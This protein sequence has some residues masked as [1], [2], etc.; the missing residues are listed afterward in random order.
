MKIGISQLNFHIG[1]FDENL[2]SVAFEIKKAQQ[3]DLDLLIFSELAVCGYP[4]LDLLEYRSFID[5]CT[6]ALERLAKICTDIAVLIGAPTV[7]PE[8]TGKKLFNSAYFLADGQIKQVFHKTLLPTYD[9]FDE[10]RYF[11]P[12]KEF[13]LLK[14]KD[15]KLAVTICE[16][17]WYEQPFEADL[18][19]KR[20]YTINPMDELI[21]EGP[22][23]IINL[24]ASPF[25]YTKI[26][27]KQNI[28][29]DN[30]R[31]YN[32]PVIYVNQVGGQT[33]LIFEG[34]SLAVTRKGVIVKEL[35]YFEN[36]SA[37]IDMD[38]LIHDKLEPVDISPMDPPAMIYQALRFGIKD[39]FN[40]S[41]FKKAVLGLSGGI[42]SAVTMIIA[43]DALGPEN[44]HALLL[45][46]AFTSEHSVSDAVKL[47]EN[48][49]VK[50]DVLNIEE[51]FQ[52][53]KGTLQPLFK[54]LPEDN[55]EENIQSRIR[56]LLLMAYSNKFGHL[57]LNTSNKSESA[58]GYGTL[59]GDMAGGLSV[60]GDVYKTDVYNLS[61]HIN[62]NKEIIPDS[63]ITKAPSAELKPGQKDTD[64]L[65]E[66][67]VLDQILFQYIENRKSYKEI[68]EMINDTA[69][70]SKIIQR[71]NQNEY[72]RYQSPPIL[73]ISS[74]SFG[75]GRRMPIA[76]KY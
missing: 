19:N 74:K 14:Y 24:A 10:Y 69:L 30:A 70:A 33:E 37:I 29:I 43:A 34:G 50:Y 56:S 32:L 54:N 3:F 28:F 8:P 13:K 72:K 6:E 1:N 62:R 31:K 53:F 45:S 26:D 9:I 25:S 57:L 12:N 35:K 21:K 76:A 27:V 64:S 16:D 15:R 7:N 51:L 58:V 59:Y 63:I 44:V 73:R 2:T 75:T 48:T 46:S 55:T 17:L 22:E 23:I 68:G 61:R 67:D 18:S 39:Y 40:K 20:L 65:P 4:P 36:D 66:Y 11:E 47:A 5:Q 71:V 60:L 49:G 38:S 52:Q 42:D 41:G